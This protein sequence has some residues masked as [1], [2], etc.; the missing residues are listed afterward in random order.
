MATAKKRGAPASAS[1]GSVAYRPGS[2]AEIERRRLVK[3]AEREK[4][5]ADFL[6]RRR[7][8]QVSVKE[9]MRARAP[10]IEPARVE[11][12]G[13]AYVYNEA[14]DNA[15]FSL[16]VCGTTLEEI[17][18]R[19]GM[20]S[21][22]TLL[23]W[24]GTKDHPFGATY[25]KAKEMLVPLYEERVVAVATKAQMGEIVVERDGIEGPSTEVRRVD[26]VE[27]SKLAV[28]AYQW[29]LSHLRPRKHGRNADPQAGQPNEQLKALFDALNAGPVE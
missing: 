20:P 1:G 15:L 16:I 6:V 8:A 9:E 10:K 25:I 13:N 12:N 14:L 28:S 21:L 23:I 19:E 7:E 11:R 24:I 26:A 29:S 18:E 17:A 2:K 5:R 4:K 3:A 22:S 27:R